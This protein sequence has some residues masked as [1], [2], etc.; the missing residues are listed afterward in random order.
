MAGKRISSDEDGGRSKRQRR[1]E[2][3]ARLAED[4]SSARQ[5]AEEYLLAT[6]TVPVDAMTRRWEGWDNRGL[7]RRQV[8]RLQHE[9]RD[10]GLFR[11]AEENFMIAQ[12]SAA[13]V[14]KMLARLGVD[15]REKALDFRDWVTVN[16]DT[17]VEVINGQPRTGPGTG[18]C[19]WGPR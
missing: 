7:S 17:K 12:C 10:V 2:K 18:Q 4:G 16:G 11:E 15:G 19:R 6:A 1:G 5:Q 8:A 3:A 14:K 9:F 13:A